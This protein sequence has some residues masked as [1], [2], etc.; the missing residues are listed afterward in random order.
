MPTMPHLLRRSAPIGLFAWALIASA[1]FCGGCTGA[2]RPPTEPF[3]NFTIKTKNNPPATI[4]GWYL[5]AKADA[6]GT[7]FLC[8]PYHLGKRN[9]VWWDWLRDRGWNLVMFDFRCF[10]ESSRAWP[11]VSTLGYYEN[12]DVRAA[13]D[14]AESKHAARPF[15]VFGISMGGAIGLKA[16]GEDKRISAVFAGSPYRNAWE[17]A[18]IRVAQL[19]YAAA[20][21]PLLNR[22]MSMY[23]AVDIP[24]AV[25]QRDDLRIWIMTRE[26]DWFPPEHQRSILNASK[27]PASLK[28]LIVVPGAGHEGFW[29]KADGDG[30][31]Y[32]LKFLDACAAAPRK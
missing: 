32:L 4:A 31:G 28:R 7:I 21:R 8:H 17:A 15:V 20:L 30:D 5:P 27:S 9:M 12:W 3:E 11:Y 24:A 25:T 6:K 1:Q 14:F 10:G 26:N 29:G 13:V 16:A 19:P 22:M 2:S 23:Q 18:Q